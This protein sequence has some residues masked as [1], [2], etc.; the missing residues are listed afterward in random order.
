MQA[1]LHEICKFLPQIPVSKIKGIKKYSSAAGKLYRVKWS[2]R[3]LSRIY[4]KIREYLKAGYYIKVP[5][6]PA[7][8]VYTWRRFQW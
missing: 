3:R 8:F 6:I 1:D 2:S 5:L 7:M 4:Y